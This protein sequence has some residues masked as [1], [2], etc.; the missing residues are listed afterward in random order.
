M[1]Q[2]S[3]LGMGKSFISSPQCPLQF[4]GPSSIF[5][6]YLGSFPWGKLVEACSWPATHSSTCN[7]KCSCTS[8]VHTDSCTSPVCTLTAVPSHTLTICC[9]IWRTK[10]G[11]FQAWTPLAPDSN[12][13]KSVERDLHWHD[14]LPEACNQNWSVCLKHWHT[15]QTLSP[16]STHIS[17]DKTALYGMHWDN[18]EIS[19]YEWTARFRHCTFKQTECTETCGLYL[20]EWFNI[21]IYIVLI[22]KMY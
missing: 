17:R 21:Y 19:M 9:Y 7:V 6:Q 4:E 16:N 11:L 18:V 20:K 1:G 8:R 2:G 13:I 5:S 22:W 3:I 10:C 14:A 12:D 15:A